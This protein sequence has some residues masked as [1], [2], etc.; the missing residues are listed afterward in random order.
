MAKIRTIKKKF[1]WVAVCLL[2]V[3]LI[4][5]A[6]QILSQ[7]FDS[8]IGK[9]LASFGSCT[10]ALFISINSF[11][12]MEK[13]NRLIQGFALVGLITNLA[14]LIF[15]IMLIWELVPSF[16]DSGFLHTQLS[17]F[18]RITSLLFDINIMCL[19]FTIIWSI[20]E[21][22]KPIRP[23]KITAIICASYCSIYEI[24]VL[25]SDTYNTINSRW[26]FLSILM[27]FA[28]IVMG[29]VAAVIS[30]NSKKRIA[31][32]KPEKS[33]DNPEIQAKIQ[34]MVEKEVQSRMGTQEKPTE[35]PVNPPNTIDNNTPEPKD[36]TENP[37]DHEN[38][39]E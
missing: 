27:G 8:S 11:S 5:G 26:Y 16:I 34:E 12:K 3:E 38:P 33:L 24:I 15:T 18:S 37:S 17:S 30:K 31:K 21:T 32:E 39:F 19:V 23:L 14:W 25:L 29:C 10:V 1:L 7:A 20:E 13:E 35:P 6:I 28:C 4:I 22:E 36:I 9:I 2:I